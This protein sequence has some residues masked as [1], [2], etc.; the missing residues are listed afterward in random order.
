MNETACFYYLHP[1]PSS[2]CSS[3]MDVY[4]GRNPTWRCRG[5]GGP[6]RGTGAVD[7]VLQEKA[8]E[9]RKPLNFDVAGVGLIYKPLL[10]QLGAEVVRRDLFLGRV[11]GRTGLLE[12]WAT[13]RGRIEVIVRGTKE[14]GYRVCE[15][16]GNVLYFARGKKQ[17]YPAPPADA[18]LYESD[19]WGLIVPPWLFE[20]LDLTRWKRG[21][22]IDRLPIVD[23]P[24]DGLGELPYA[25]RG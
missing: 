24:A 14:A 7:V 10:E 23:A 17:L 19:S 6:R 5:C 9:I 1:A 16:C 15:D 11:F 13:F 20:S 21:M 3:N 4:P 18:T 8:S 2:S 22:T 12:D 25:V